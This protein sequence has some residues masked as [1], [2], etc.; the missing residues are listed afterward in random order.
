MKTILIDI[1]KEKIDISDNEIEILTSNFQIITKQKNEYLVIEGSKSLYLYFIID[2]F[3]RYFHIDDGNE[4][5]TQISTTKD[6]V[7]S[8]ESFLNNSF[9]KE[10]IQCTSDCT[11]L[12]ISKDEYQN[13]YREV[14]NWSL[15]CKNV[16]EDQIRKISERAN[17]LQ[18]LSASQRYLKLLNKQPKI[19]LNTAV[20]HLASYLGIKPQS[21]S[22]IRKEVIK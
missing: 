7:T 1:I 3:V 8:F 16:Y 22:R 15:F 17:S 11:L 13:L 18:K 4:I 19:A 9:S 10:N 6:F 14:S 12:R 21:L 5:T 20:K 2:G